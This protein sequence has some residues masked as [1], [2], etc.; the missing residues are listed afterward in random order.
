MQCAVFSCGLAG[1][2]LFFHTISIGKI[3]EKKNL[4]NKKMRVFR[5]SPQLLSETVPILRRIEQNMI[6]NVY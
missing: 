2:T 4:L 5:I 3:F 6:K 1:S